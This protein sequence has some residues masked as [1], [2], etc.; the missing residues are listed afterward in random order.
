MLES[1]ANIKFTCLYYIGC[2]LYFV[3]LE[4]YLP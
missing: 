1:D 3:K 2:N 4:D